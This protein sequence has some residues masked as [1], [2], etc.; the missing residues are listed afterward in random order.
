MNRRLARENQRFQALRLKQ[1]VKGLMHAGEKV[2][3]RDKAKVALRD[4]IRRVKEATK[5]HEVQKEELKKEFQELDNKIGE[6]IDH[7]LD[8]RLLKEEGMVGKLQNKIEEL[9]K[10]VKK[11]ESELAE[12]RKENTKLRVKH[13][14]EATENIKQKSNSKRKEKRADKP[15]DELIEKI[16][17]IEWF[18]AEKEEQGVDPSKLKP[19]KDRVKELK[20]KVNAHKK[21]NSKKRKKKS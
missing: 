13:V 18:I 9:E 14:V 8:A 17:K 19:L 4:Q 1:F 2:H 3:K 7:E 21:K 6:H 20:Q 15:H 10:R 16:K 5:K 11:L 12:E